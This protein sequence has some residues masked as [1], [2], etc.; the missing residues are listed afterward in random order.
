[1]RIRQRSVS[2]SGD[3]VL[4][5]AAVCG[6]TTARKLSG[7]APPKINCVYKSYVALRLHKDTPKCDIS[8][9]AQH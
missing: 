8:A 7:Y 3:T 5:A 1:M 4:P 6:I 9:L 2:A